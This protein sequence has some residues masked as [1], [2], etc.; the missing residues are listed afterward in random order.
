MFVTKG[1]IIMKDKCKHLVF[2]IAFFWAFAGCSQETVAISPENVK[3][4]PLA[5]PTDT[6]KPS[7]TGKELFNDLDALAEII[8]RKSQPEVQ[9]LLGEC[10][11]DLDA[12]DGYYDS[13][14]ELVE[15]QYDKETGIV[16]AAKKNSRKIFFSSIERSSHVQNLIDNI[17]LLA[18]EIEGKTF[19]E[20][21]ELL[22]EAD[23]EGSGFFCEYYINSSHERVHV[24]YDRE[25]MLV[26]YIK[27]ENH[28]ISLVS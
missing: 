26:E 19:D 6:F 15:I 27:A 13:N 9:E 16:A 24:Y 23:G 12:G 25:T 2:L 3:Q 21:H 18:D 28:L 20:I 10:D 17:E 22:G 4:E 1:I 7:L 8:E 14:N 5:S 11:V